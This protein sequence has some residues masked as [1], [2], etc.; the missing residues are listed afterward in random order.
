MSHWKLI[1][2]LR[3]A[4]L[5]AFCYSVRLPFQSL[6]VQSETGRKSYRLAHWDPGWGGSAKKD[7]S[8]V[9]P[10][11]LP[12]WSSLTTKSGQLQCLDLR[13]RCLRSWSLQDCYRCETHY[14]YLCLCR[15][16]PKFF[17]LLVL[18]CQSLT[19][20]VSIWAFKTSQVLLGVQNQRDDLNCLGIDCH[21]FA[22]MR[23]N[24][25]FLNGM[26]LLRESSS[27]DL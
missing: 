18:R 11:F 13:W 20:R 10:S 19:A 26:G 15:R 27:Q 16:L 17:Y 1:E 9:L 6:G 7:F 5:S 24:Y 8:F 21:P 23:R 14:C 12:S 22:R 3:R 4:I 2:C 25:Q